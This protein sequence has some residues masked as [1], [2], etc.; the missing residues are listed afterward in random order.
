[1]IGRSFSR[2]MP[3]SS[4]AIIHTEAR[5][6]PISGVPVINVAVPS[7]LMLSETQVSPPMLNQK[8]EA[9]PRPWFASSGAR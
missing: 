5:D 3:S 9:I 2:S 4:A 1:M 6:P 7:S 8:P